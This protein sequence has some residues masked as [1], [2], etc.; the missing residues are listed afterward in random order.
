M[1]LHNITK[2]TCPNNLDVIVE[3]LMM[4][5]CRNDFSNLNS[6]QSMMEMWNSFP[7]WLLNLFVNRMLMC[8]CIF[9]QCQAMT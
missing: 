2:T 6:W 5:S 1:N 7:V 9:V 3:L 8:D 4:L